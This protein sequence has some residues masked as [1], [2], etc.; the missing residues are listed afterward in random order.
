MTTVKLKRRRDYAEYTD[1]SRQ[2][3]NCKKTFE[4]DEE[5]L[6]E[7]ETVNSGYVC[8]DCYDRYY[9]RC[10]NCSKLFKMWMSPYRTVCDKCYRE[11]SGRRLVRD[12]INVEIKYDELENPIT[13]QI[14]N[15]SKK[16]SEDGYGPYFVYRL[17]SPLTI[18]SVC[19]LR[20]HHDNLFTLLKEYP[21]TPPH[22]LSLIYVGPEGITSSHTTNLCIMNSQLYKYID[23]FSVL[24]YEQKFKRVLDIFEVISRL[25]KMNENVY[26]FIWDLH[27]YYSDRMHDILKKY[28]F[29]PSN[30][31]SSFP[32]RLL[33][34]DIDKLLVLMLKWRGLH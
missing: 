23:P 5:Q 19:E 3:E 11:L 13:E 34:E 25:Y 28:G 20:M 15:L 18:G 17:Y 12:S 26:R 29:D 9:N 1:F 2:C 32:D 8:Y 27:R 10:E 16:L 7:F 6:D 22:S 24:D 31:I 4:L 21:P 14:V 30:V 33:N